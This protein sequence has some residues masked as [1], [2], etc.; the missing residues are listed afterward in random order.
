MTNNKEEI[1]METPEDEY[2]IYPWNEIAR[3]LVDEPDISKIV[4]VRRR[5]FRT[6]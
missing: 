5:E 1:I 6:Y 4:K 3:V 2:V